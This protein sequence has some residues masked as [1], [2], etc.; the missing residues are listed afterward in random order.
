MYN[1]RL[2]LRQI[3]QLVLD[4]Q[5]PAEAPALF[6][7]C[8]VL[9]CAICRT[10]AKMW[11]EGHRDLVLPRVPGHEFVVEAPDRQRYAVWPG[12]SC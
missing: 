9:F 8:K 2:V 5:P 3:E 4:D 12:K 11:H 6:R 7:R 10:D 1:M